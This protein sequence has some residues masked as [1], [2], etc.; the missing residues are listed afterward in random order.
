MSDYK[1][2][3]VLV[4]IKGHMA[5]HLRAKSKDEAKLLGYQIA[6]TMSESGS[7]TIVPNLYAWNVEL[8][9]GNTPVIEK[10]EADE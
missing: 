8:D 6:K 10:G 1:M 3:E 2:Y 4:P 7:Q 9:V 5:V